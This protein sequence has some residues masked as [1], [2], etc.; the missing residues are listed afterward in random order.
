MAGDFFVVRRGATAVPNQLVHNKDLS[1]AALALLVVSLSMPP[2]ARVGY[3]ELTGRGMGEKATRQA[4]KEL[5]TL[6]YR[7]RFT[8]R[9]NGMLRDLTIVSDEPLTPAE[10]FAEAE[11]MMIAGGF[12]ESVITACSSHPDF[13]IQ[14]P[15]TGDPHAGV[16]DETAGRT[17]RTRLPHG[18]NAAVE[19]QLSTGGDRAAPVAARC[20]QHKQGKT[21]GRTVQCSTVARSSTAQVSKDTFKES[22]LRSDSLTHQPTTHDSGVPDV[23]VV[24]GQESA[25]PVLDVA[26][27]GPSRSPNW[28]LI[29]RCVPQSHRKGL[30]GKAAHRVSEGL[31]TLVDAGWTPRRI[32][33]R[34]A[35]NPLPPAVRN[36]PGLL[37]A[38]LEALKEFPAPNQPADSRLRPHG[39]D[40]PPNLPVLS[41]DERIEALKA[42]SEA[43][44][45]FKDKYSKQRTRS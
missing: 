34:L 30:M 19:N 42:H 8:H 20:D 35:D 39:D 22:S 2:G 16:G 29:A 44:Q 45:A 37:I 15:V 31:E 36:P 41:Q 27:A 33:E 10:A 24:G 18:E 26:P 43:L 40:S 28:D 12:A 6:N 3:R 23:G 32:N 11:Q 5:E 17:V 25:H 9:R 21:A 13:I 7:F 1:Y 14:D 4:L 38:R